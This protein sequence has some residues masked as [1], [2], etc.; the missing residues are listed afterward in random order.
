MVTLDRI[1]RFVPRCRREG[2][3]L[4]ASKKRSDIV[5]MSEVNY[6]GLAG[7]LI[8]NYGADARAQAARLTEEALREADGEAV[9]DWRAVEQAIALLTN[10]CVGTRQ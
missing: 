7:M 2:S 9:A 5:T 6:F 1:R 10:N 4:E 3:A 8:D